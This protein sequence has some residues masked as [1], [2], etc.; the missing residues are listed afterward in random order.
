MRALSISSHARVL[1]RP[2]TD[3]VCP[4]AVAWF[5]S[6]F[7]SAPCGPFHWKA[8]PP[9]VALSGSPRPLPSQFPLPQTL[10][11]KLGGGVC[12]LLL[13]LVVPTCRPVREASLFSAKV[14]GTTCPE[15]L[16]SC[17]WAQDARACSL[18]EVCVSKG[19]PGIQREQTPT[20]P[21]V[22]ST[23]VPS[24]PPPPAQVLWSLGAVGSAVAVTLRSCFPSSSP[25]AWGPVGALTQTPLA[26]SAPS[27]VEFKW[28]SYV[29]LVTV[30]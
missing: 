27:V 11:D 22:C 23:L 10:V 24:C 5:R 6:L 2:L 25:V 7:S 18:C 8:A 13:E 16:R 1:G 17:P 15:R 12:L 4:G 14:R 9:P 21:S 30:W 29:S 28:H 19:G 3:P 20:P 26:F